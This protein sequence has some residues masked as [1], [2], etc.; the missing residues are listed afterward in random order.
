MR[1]FRRDGYDRTTMRAVADE[2]GVSLGNA[3]YYFSSKEH[4]VQAFYDGLQVE[5]AAAAAERP[6][7]ARRRSPRGCAGCWTPGS[8]SR[9]RTT[10]S[11]ASSS[12][13]PPTRAARC[14]RS[15]RSRRRPARPASR[16]SSR[17]STGSDLKVAAALRRELPELL[18]LLQ[19][20][21][22]L[23]WVYDDSA[24]QARTRALVASVVPA[25]RPAGP[26]VPAARRP[27]PGRRPGEGALR[28]SRGRLGRRFR[29]QRWK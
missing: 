21:V 1:L 28:H 19:M 9:R 24:G 26:A 20:G 23:F 4:L 15:A 17:C 14:R 25:R 22:V 3:Y 27:R 6:R 8:T 5:H 11:P 10:S 13:T 16:S 2:A 29:T 12:R 18:W 7:R